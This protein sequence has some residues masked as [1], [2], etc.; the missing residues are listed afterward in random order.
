MDETQPLNK[1]HEA[2]GIRPPWVNTNPIVQEEES[3]ASVSVP[4]EYHDDAPANAFQELLSVLDSIWKRV[5]LLLRDESSPPGEKVQMLSVA[6]REAV[7]IAR[8]LGELLVAFQV[9]AGDYNLNL[10][11]LPVDNLIDKVLKQCE[12][13]AAYKAIILTA[14][15]ESTENVQ[16]DEKLLRRLLVNLL[17]CVIRLSSR[18]AQVNI[19]THSINQEL[20]IEIHDDTHGIQMENFR[21]LFSRSPKEDRQVSDALALDPALLAAQPIVKGHRGEIRFSEGSDLKGSIIIS[22]PIAEP[23]IPALRT[24]EQILIVDD[25]VEGTTLMELALNGAGFETLTASSG[26]EGWVKAH[27]KR[28]GLVILDVMIPGMD[29][30]ELCHRLRTAND[31]KDLP[32]IM[33]S[34]KARDEDIATGLRVGANVYMPKP[35]KMAAF[36]N[37]V[38]KFHPG[39]NLKDQIEE[40]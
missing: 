32:I 29:G 34:A 37:T 14:N 30:F 24:G 36:L 28:V 13:N 12:P 11:T 27:D 25:D 6:Q 33:I 39:T 21:G 7:H 18:G 5:Q 40:T 20:L 16:G 10:A 3:F 22:L 8:R 31:T 17:N 38:Q 19:T 26:L 15:T 9:E 4:L 23:E 35:L 1:T 2:N